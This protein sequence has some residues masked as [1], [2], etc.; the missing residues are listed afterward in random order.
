MSLVHNMNVLHLLD[1]SLPLHSGYSFRSRNLLEAQQRMGLCPVA[2]TS[3]RHNREANEAL[4]PFEDIENIRYYRSPSIHG[5]IPGPAADL[6]LMRILSKRCRQVC[7]TAQAQLIH[8][9]SP[10]LNCMPAFPVGK[11][12][13]IPVVYEIRAFWEDAGV[14]QGTYRENSLKYRAVRALETWAC[15]RASQVMVICNG[16]KQDLESRGIDSNKITIIGNGIDIAGFQPCEPDAVLRKEYDLYNKKVIAFMGSFYHYE[17]L[18][19]LVD[20]FKTIAMRRSDT[21]LLLIGGG[22]EDEKLKAQVRSLNLEGKVQFPGRIP[23]ERIPAIY[24][25]SDILAFPRYSMRLTELVTPLKPLE[26]MAMAK[27]LVASNIGGHRELVRDGKTGLLFEPGS[28]E[29]LA[30]AL[31]L[32]L[33]NPE[34]GKTLGQ[35]GRDW[36]SRER[37]WDKVTAP[38][39]QVYEKALRTIKKVTS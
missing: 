5:G 13:G 26:A 14:D 17:G 6:N 19:L 25:L 21:V 35:Q 8:A 15:R 18:N 36:V 20:A 3:P 16:L 12:L 11:S 30:K 23:H 37:T 9:H 10:I 4:R 22:A 2:L 7:R 1:H 38:Y 39:P 27:P 24:A 31:E 34:L 28:K 33:D 32:L 29:S